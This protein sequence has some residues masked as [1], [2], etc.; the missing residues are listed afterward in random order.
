MSGWKLAATRLMLTYKTHIDKDTMREWWRVEFDPKRV[1]MAHENGHK[2]KEAKD[3]EEVRDYPHTHVFVE[4]K[5]QFQTRDARKFDY[6][7]IHPHI[8]QVMTRKHH[9]SIFQYLC[10]EDHSNDHLMEEIGGLVKKVWRANTIQEAVVD[11]V[12]RPSDVMGIVALYKLKPTEYDVV[13]PVW[14]PWQREIIRL[15][16]G[17]PDDRTVHWVVDVEGACGKTFLAKYLHMKGQAYC[18]SAFGGMRDVG[19]IIATAIENGWDKKAFIADLPRDAEEK[20]IYE[21]IEAIKNG[22]VTSTKYVGSSMCFPS[23]HVIVF[24]NF[25]PQKYRLSRDRWRTYSIDPSSGELV[26]AS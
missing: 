5:K 21:P 20:A 12:E 18:V 3:D 22:L 11:N 16:T 14:R 2:K 9:D 25:S 23:P 26:S 10:K 17:I 19:T 6:E 1:E 13:E 24:A 8:K 15:L 7:E 4:F